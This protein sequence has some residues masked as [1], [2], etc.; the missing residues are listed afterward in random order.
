MRRRWLRS[1]ATARR[2]RK[3]LDGNLKVWLRTPPQWPTPLIA[4]RRKR[5]EGASNG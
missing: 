1:K 4:E 3:A 2:L 5:M